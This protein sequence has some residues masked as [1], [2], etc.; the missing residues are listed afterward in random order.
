VCGGGEERIE[1]TEDDS[2]EGAEKGEGKD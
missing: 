2:D 1:C